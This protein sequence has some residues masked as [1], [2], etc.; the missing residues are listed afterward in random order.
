MFIGCFVKIEIEFL[1]F[2][3]SGNKKS[4]NRSKLNNC[5]WSNN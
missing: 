5:V 3:I 2:P 4:Y 1:H